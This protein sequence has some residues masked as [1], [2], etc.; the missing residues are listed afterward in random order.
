MMRKLHLSSLLLLLVLAAT[1][2]SSSLAQEEAAKP[3][4]IVIKDD[5]EQGMDRWEPTEAAKWQI[6]QL[7]PENAVLELL[8]KSNYQP[9]HR[10]PHSI[11]WLKDVVVEDFVITVDVQTTQTSRGHRDM[12]VFFGEQNA[13]N[14]YYV[15]LGE[16]T[17]DHSNQIFRVKDAPR[18][19][20][21]DKTTK[22][23]PWKDATWHKI[24]VVRKVESGLIEVYFDDMETPQL[25]APDKSFGAGRVGL[26]S[27]DDM[28]YFD[29]FEL[30]GTTAADAK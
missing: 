5:F 11:V 24:K 9:P 10:S 3:S 13:A 4:E 21:S 6:H 19:K 25:T 28:G 17:D 12:C 18:I 27:F 7:T 1:W 29:N 14:F 16:V 20:I 15:H 22:G 23:T 30:R 2:T 8:G 26:G